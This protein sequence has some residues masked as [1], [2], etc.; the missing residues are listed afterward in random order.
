MKEINYN[1]N[2]IEKKKKQL[3]NNFCGSDIKVYGCVLR[4]K[5]LNGMSI[6]VIIKKLMFA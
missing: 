4:I 2:N 1:N 6:N 3:I 5:N